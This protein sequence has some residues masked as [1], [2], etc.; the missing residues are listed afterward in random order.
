MVKKDKDPKRVAAGKRSKSKGK[1]FERLLVKKL[2]EAGFA[3]AKR[4]WWQSGETAKFRGPKPSVP[5]IFLDGFWLEAGHGAKMD[6]YKKLDQALRDFPGRDSGLIPVAITR[7]DRE[8]VIRVTLASFDLEELVA[9][10]RGEKRHGW[11]SPPGSVQPIFR[12]SL[13]FEEFC[14]LLT[15]ARAHEGHFCA[16]AEIP[17]AFEGADDLES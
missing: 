3:E 16:H 7:R 8:R 13:R 15:E 2:K 10:S 5:D 11:R 4:G 9:R 14:T 17:S 6:D 1:C 12:V